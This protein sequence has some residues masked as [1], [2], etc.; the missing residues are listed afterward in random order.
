VRRAIAAIGRVL[1]TL[2]LLIL[3]FVAYQLWGT[4]LITARAQSDLKNDFTKAR[5]QYA[6][7][8][9]TTTIADPPSSTISVPK[10]TTTLPTR[11]APPVPAEGAV[12]GTIKIPKIGVN[13]AF[14]EGVERDDLKKGPGHYPDTPM[15]GTIGNAAIAGHRTTYGAPFYDI[16]KLQAG[17]QIHVET[18]AGKFTYEMYQ[19]L[20]V[21]PTDVYVA[22]NTY[23][24]EAPCGPKGQS[25]SLT[26][27]S[28]NPRFSAEQRIVI[29]A[30]LVA[31]E[32]DKPTKAQPPKQSSRGGKSVSRQAV[33]QEGLSGQERSADSAVRWG[34]AVLLV[35]LGWWW[36]FRRW[37]HPVTW[38]AGVVPF[39]AVLFAFYVY[40]EQALP[41]GY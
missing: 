25:C 10:T 28:C 6:A 8:Q 20:I 40:F 14:V 16:D 31:N 22:D 18:L 17:D 41:A 21:K 24:P 12:E 4:G 33:L 26:L 13:W 9:S 29:K 15:P 36:A 2:G 3:L 38:I 34:L 35:G 37:R 7:E 30:R 23:H 32:S 5:A 11:P 27:T 19:Q 39:L 1:V